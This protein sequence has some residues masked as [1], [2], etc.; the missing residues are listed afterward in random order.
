MTFIEKGKPERQDLVHASGK[1][2]AVRNCKLIAGKTNL[3]NVGDVVIENSR[4]TCMSGFRKILCHGGNT[5]LRK[6]GE[7]AVLG[8]SDKSASVG[9]LE[10][11]KEHKVRAIGL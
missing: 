5:E 4:M 7:G 11:K 8:I 2:E 10:W 3:L 1:G 9:N 6:T